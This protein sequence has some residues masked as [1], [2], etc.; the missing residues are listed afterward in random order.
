MDA[1]HESGSGQ[2]RDTNYRTNNNLIDKHSARKE[3]SSLWSTGTSTLTT[4]YGRR[5]PAV[6]ANFPSDN[7]VVFQQSRKGDWSLFR[8]LNYLKSA[9]IVTTI[10]TGFCKIQAFEGM[11]V[12]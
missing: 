4:I 8:R 1:A 7:F 11:A 3:K 10:T 5:R 6:E 9:T 12:E 2:T